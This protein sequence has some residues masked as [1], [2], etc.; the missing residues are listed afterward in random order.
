MARLR[1]VAIAESAGTVESVDIEGSPQEDTLGS[2]AIVVT[3][4]P[5]PIV[6]TASK[7]PIA[8]TNSLTA[9]EFA[10]RK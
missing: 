1:T 4:S 7:E 3:A 2:A 9:G 8:A 10:L 6:V 5:K